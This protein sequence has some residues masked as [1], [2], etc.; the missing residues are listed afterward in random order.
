[1][2][3]TFRIA[4]HLAASGANGPD[5]PRDSWSV[6][7]FPGHADPASTGL[8]LTRLAAPEFAPRSGI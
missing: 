6:H 3:T 1:M 7:P 8:I 2:Q 5:E 4:P